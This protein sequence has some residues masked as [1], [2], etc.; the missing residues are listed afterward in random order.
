MQEYRTSLAERARIWAADINDD[1]N[2]SGSGRHSRR[3]DAI[4]KYMLAVLFL[5]GVVILI[6]GLVNLTI[7]NT[8][9]G[10]ASTAATVIFIGLFYLISR[11]GRFDL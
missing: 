11:P 2:Y 10:V 1:W 5:A 3:P 8:A 4:I 6:A 9:V 7:V